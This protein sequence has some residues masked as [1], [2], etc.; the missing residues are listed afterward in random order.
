[1][2]GWFNLSGVSFQGPHGP[3]GQRGEIGFPG[4]PVSQ[5]QTLILDVYTIK[6]VQICFKPCSMQGR[7][8]LNGAKGEK[9]DSGGGSGFGYPVS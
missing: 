5:F 4:R 2:S 8:G 6:M 3:A 9:G 7:P 1:M